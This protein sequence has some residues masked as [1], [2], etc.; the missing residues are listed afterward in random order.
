MDSTDLSRLPQGIRRCQLYVGRGCFAGY[1][2]FIAL[3]W[4]QRGLGQL[5]VTNPKRNEKEWEYELAAL[6]QK[7]KM[8]EMGDPFNDSMANARSKGL[9]RLRARRI[10]DYPHELIMTCHLRSFGAV[11]E[12]HSFMFSF[13]LQNEISGDVVIIESGGLA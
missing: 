7:D 1:T 2:A 11:G 9:Y 13:T 5:M 3:S 4:G 12:T 8:G 6:Y 10:F